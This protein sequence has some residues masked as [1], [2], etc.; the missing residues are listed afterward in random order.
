MAS[1]HHH[2]STLAVKHRHTVIGVT[3]ADG[4]RCSGTQGFNGDP[5]GPCTVRRKL[6]ERAVPRRG[7]DH[8]I[9]LA[10]PATVRARLHEWG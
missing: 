9:T 5:F 6:R 4:E 3:S 8:T 1:L 7:A 2:L 10:C